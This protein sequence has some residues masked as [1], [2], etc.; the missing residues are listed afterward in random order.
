VLQSARSAYLRAEEE[1]PKAERD[2]RMI[3]FVRYVRSAIAAG[4]NLALLA[5]PDEDEDRFS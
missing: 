5:P 1:G 4:I 2:L 3:M